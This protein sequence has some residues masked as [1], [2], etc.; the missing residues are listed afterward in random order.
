MSLNIIFMFVLFIGSI[1]GVYPPCDCLEKAKK[2]MTYQFESTLSSKV[3]KPA[4][5]FT[6]DR[7]VVW[8][9]HQENLD[10]PWIFYWSKE[11]GIEPI[12]LKEELALLGYKKTSEPFGTG[13]TSFYEYYPIHLDQYGNVFLTLSVKTEKMTKKTNKIG[14]WNRCFGFKFLEVP[15]LESLDKCQVTNELLIVSGL[16]GSSLCSKLVLL[17]KPK[18]FWELPVEEPIP[19]AAPKVDIGTPWDNMPIGPLGAR[20][21]ALEKLLKTKLTCQCDNQMI[22]L[23]FE[24]EAAHV[25]DTLKFELKKANEQIKQAAL[26]GK[27]NEE[28]EEVYRSAT[29]HIEALRNYLKVVSLTRSKVFSLSLP[30]DQW[31]PSI[32]Y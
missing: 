26:K 7:E 8:A 15:G 30:S 10:K 18:S 22:S 24:A 20:L 13:S 11:G 1:H 28:A 5:F 25:L 16:D 3:I 17:N 4:S 27:I 19:I 12:D 31:V 6:N 29:Q 14:V 2:E 9:E 32:T 21:Y 23:I